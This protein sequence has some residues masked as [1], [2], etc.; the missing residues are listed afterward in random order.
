VTRL[1]VIRIG[2]Y[3]VKTTKLAVK[4][5]KAI[6]DKLEVPHVLDHVGFHNTLADLHRMKSLHNTRV[7]KVETDGSVSLKNRF[8][9]SGRYNYRYLIIKS[10]LEFQFVDLSLLSTEEAEFLSDQI[11]EFEFMSNVSA[12][13]GQNLIR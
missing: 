2:K 11:Y 8:G 5:F 1:S 12:T 3:K 4:R 10:L 6:L 7:W 9:H 13:A